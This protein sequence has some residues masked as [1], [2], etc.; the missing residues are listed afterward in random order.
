MTSL[1]CS[2]SC[3][4][5][6]HSDSACGLLPVKEAFILSARPALHTNNKLIASWPPGLWSTFDVAVTLVFFMPN[7]MVYNHTV[8]QYLVV[9]ML[10]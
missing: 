3:N 8:L 2:K 7:S 9:H 10:L 4:V 6:L 5:A 1:L